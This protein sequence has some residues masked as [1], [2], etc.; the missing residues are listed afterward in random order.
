MNTDDINNSNSDIIYK[1]DNNSS[2]KI[3]NKLK[4]TIENNEKIKKDIK[5]IN[6]KSDGNCFYRC[7]AYFLLE[8][9]EFY[10]DIKNMIIEWIDKN[11]NKFIDFF[12]DI[13]EQNLSKEEQAKVEFNYIKSKNSWGDH[14][15][16]EIAS[17]IFKISIAVYT[18]ID[19]N[20]YKKYISYTLLNNDKDLMI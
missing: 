20:N 8:N 4:S 15:T 1:Y 18:E 7:F 9:E 19:N 5:I 14:Y 16:F 2:F 10:T 11:Y 6:I 17:L 12:G 3:N 13:D